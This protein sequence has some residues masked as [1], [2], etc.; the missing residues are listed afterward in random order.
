MAVDQNLPIQAEIEAVNESEVK[1][2]RLNLNNLV[3]ATALTIAFFLFSSSPA[4]AQQSQPCPLDSGKSCVC[5]GG[6]T[7]SQ[8]LSC[9]AEFFKPDTGVCVFVSRTEDITTCSDGTVISDT[10]IVGMRT[11]T[12]STADQCP[13]FCDDSGGLMCD[14]ICINH[15]D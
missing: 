6:D 5:S 9:T 1:I 13:T 12:P 8:H 2:M 10:G 11:R 14:D 3:W 4:H 15:A 7:T